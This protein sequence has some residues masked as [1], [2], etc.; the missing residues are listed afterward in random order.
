[1]NLDKREVY[2]ICGSKLGEALISG[3]Y[4]ELPFLLSKP[5]SIRPISKVYLEQDI[6]AEALRD[7][8]CASP[9][10]PRFIERKLTVLGI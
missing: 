7:E 1:M 2:S 3:S 5:T 9:R 4:T 6:I 8:K 10:K